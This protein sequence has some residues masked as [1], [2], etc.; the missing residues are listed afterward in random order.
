VS[1]INVVTAI[2]TVLLISVGIARLVPTYTTSS[3]S[4]DEPF[5]IACGMEWLDKGVYTY[6]AQHPPLARVAD[7]LGP[8]LAELRSHSARSANPEDKQPV[9]GV[10]ELGWA[11]GNAIL[12]A[13][14][15]YWRNLT[16]AR[17]GALPFLVLACAGIV[18]WARRWFSTGA[19]MWALLLF[20]SLPPV[21]AAAGQATTDMACAATVFVALY[22]FMRWLEHPDARRSAIFGAALGLALL[23]KFSSIPFLAACC[24]VALVYFA[25][26]TRDWRGRTYGRWRPLC[27]IGGVAFVLVWAGY[28][29]SFHP[30]LAEPGYT[31]TLA[32]ISETSP[33]LGRAMAEIS[34]IP[35]PMPELPHGIYMVF[36]HN[37]FGHESYLFGRY[38]NRGCWY[39]FPVIVA[40]KTPLG[41]LLLAAL[42]AAA[43][44]WRKESSPWRRLTVL[45]PVALMLVC[46]TSRINAGLRHI[47]PIYPLLAVLAGHAISSSFSLQNRAKWAVAPVVVLLAGWAVVDSWIAQPDYIAYFNQLAGSH[48]ERI[49]IESDIGQDVHRLSLALR[50]LDAKEVAIQISTSAELAKE[51]LPPFSDVPRYRKVSGFVAI[52][53][54]FFEIGYAQNKSYGWLREYT[55]IQRVGKTISLY[56]IPE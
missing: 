47:L 21:L 3:A 28:R 37:Q 24:A 19:A 51:G 16:L 54:W 12:Y 25:L 46:M 17:L 27:I 53:D 18:L 38:Q 32:G 7:A 34:K 22:Q 30:I 43:I 45:F 48:P 26:V 8:Y 49:T 52:S 5:H 41:F 9:A 56:F 55:P 4:I 10:N 20:I 50:S 14:G 1:R 39:F 42:G 11:E 23:S 35:L 40:I 33:R 31:K 2:G 6:E 13:D 29:F 15:N 44:V 36:R